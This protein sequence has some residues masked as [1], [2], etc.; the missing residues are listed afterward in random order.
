M[1]KEKTTYNTLPEQI[2]YLIQEIKEIKSMLS[3]KIEKPEEIPRWLNK[4]QALEY[5]R[6]RGYMISSSKFYKMS[7]QDT[8]PCYRSGNRLYFVAEELDE[9]LQKQ[10]ERK[11]QTDQNLE[12][13]L[14]K[15]IV[16]SEKRNGRKIYE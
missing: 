8:L 15:F 13:K 7:A 2:D 12:S 9:W 3:C 1:D 10:V 4:V 16:K 14:I 6:E 5:I 11:N